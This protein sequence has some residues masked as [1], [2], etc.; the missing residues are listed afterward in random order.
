MLADYCRT[1]REEVPQAKYSRESSTVTVSVMYIF[2]A[3]KSKYRRSSK[4]NRAS[5]ET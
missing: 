1:L 5:L 4:S 3:L 2:H